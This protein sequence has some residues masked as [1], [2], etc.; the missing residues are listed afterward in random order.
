MLVFCAEREIDSSKEMVPQ[1]TRLQPEGSVGNLLDMFD[2]SEET[3]TTFSVQFDFS[4]TIDLKGRVTLGERK[5][6]RKREKQ[7]ASF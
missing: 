1:V 2:G 7:T 3:N 4:V 5:T 6:K